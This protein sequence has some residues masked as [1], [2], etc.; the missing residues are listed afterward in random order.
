[1]S[2]RDRRTG[3]EDEEGRQ[4]GC[5][6]RERGGRRRKLRLKKNERLGRVEVSEKAISKFNWPLKRQL[7]FF[8]SCS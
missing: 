3:D 8:G 1:M 7:E 4:G 2:R 5:E 6:E